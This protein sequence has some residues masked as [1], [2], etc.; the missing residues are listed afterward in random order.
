M[1]NIIK[2]IIVLIFVPLIL[3]DVVNVLQS[4]ATGNISWQVFA[5]SAFF[6][7]FPIIIIIYDK[8]SN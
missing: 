1:N 4:M 3:I 8:I 2:F 6:L 5:L 7:S